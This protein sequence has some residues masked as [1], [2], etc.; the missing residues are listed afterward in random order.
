MK[1]LLSSI[2]LLLLSTIAFGQVPNTFSSGETIS[3]SKINANFSFLSDALSKGNVTSMMMC[4]S[5]YVV[6]KDDSSMASDDQILNPEMVFGDCFSD[7]V[8]FTQYS[9]VCLPMNINFDDSG[10]LY[11]SSG[12][13]NK[14]IISSKELI[15]QGWL[16][17]NTAVIT[18]SKIQY[19][20][21]KVS[22]D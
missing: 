2:I 20:F 1:H 16:L 7:N 17:Q 6:N 15:E 4:K 14:F 8:T 18:S 22:S 13:Y 9:Y 10:N 12:S 19:W 3:S 21:Y 11:C 5:A